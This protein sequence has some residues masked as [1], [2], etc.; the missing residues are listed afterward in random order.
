MPVIVWDRKNK[1]KYP[2]NGVFADSSEA[3]AWLRKHKVKN[4]H[5]NNDQIAYDEITVS[6]QQ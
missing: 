1:V 2:V 4:G 3:Q 5:K 6:V